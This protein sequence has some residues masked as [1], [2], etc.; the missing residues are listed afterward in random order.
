MNPLSRRAA[1]LTGSAALVAGCARGSFTGTVRTIGPGQ[2]YATTYT[3]PGAKPAVVS[4]LKDTATATSTMTVSDAVVGSAQ[5]IVTIGSSVFTFN[6][7][8]ATDIGSI[9]DPLAPV[10]GISSR[11]TMSCK[12]RT[13]PGCPLR[14]Y[15]RR[16]AAPNA[17]CSIVFEHGNALTGVADGFAAYGPY[18]VTVTDGS[19]GTHTYSNITHYYFSRWRHVFNTWPFAVTPTA[20]LISLGLVP[21]F[22]AAVGGSKLAQPRALTYS[23]PM[24]LVNIPTYMSAGGEGDNIGLFD[25]WQGAYLCGV[26]T[27]QHLADMLAELEGSASEA[28]HFR[29]GTTGAPIDTVTYPNASMWGNATSGS[30]PWLGRNDAYP[31][32]NYPGIEVDTSHMPDMAYVPFLLQGDPYALEEMQFVAN[33]TVLYVPPGARGTN[34]RNDWG[35]SSGAVRGLTWSIRNRARAARCTPTSVPGWLKPKSYWQTMMD[36]ELTWLTNNYV[37]NP[38]APFS[39]L[40]IMGGDPTGNPGFPPSLPQNSYFAPWME[41]YFASTVGHVVEMGFSTWLPVFTWSIYYQ[42]NLNNGTSG[43]NRNTPMLYHAVVRNGAGSPFVTDFTTFF[44][45]NLSLGVDGVANS[46]PAHR[47]HVSPY[48]VASQAALAI[49]ARMGITGAEACRA[50]LLGEIQ[51]LA[52]A[53]GIAAQWSIA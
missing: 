32:S 26:N 48:D 9:S 18:N 12:L 21:H 7:T 1:L 25:G 10:L 14:V 22:D 31:G 3:T 17:W 42:V 47:D 29:D 11:F 46:S 37:N 15:F 35:L 51:T 27:T 19:G 49:A 34:V 28:W 2:A 50:W 39:S 41:S 53:F 43:W 40:H 44:N 24:S 4:V 33:F 13:L 6:E 30:N 16:I 38:A 52:P 23:G 45:L 36:N 20:T 8:D 5:A